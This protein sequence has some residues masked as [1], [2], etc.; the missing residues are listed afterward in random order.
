LSE[1]K[2]THFNNFNLSRSASNLTHS[3]YKDINEKATTTTT[4]T[5]PP[6]GY[7]TLTDAFAAACFLHNHIEFAL[8]SRRPF[9]NRK[10]LIRPTR[11]SISHLSFSLFS[12]SNN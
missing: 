9:I 10:N 2:L 3:K 1:Q 6:F 11:F 4:T 5:T 7:T 8:C 12:F